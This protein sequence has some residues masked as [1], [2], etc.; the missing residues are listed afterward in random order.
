MMAQYRCIKEQHPGTLLFY[1]MG[2]FYEMFFD[3]A[4]EAADALSIALTKR[5]KSH[6][7]DIPMCGVPVHSA[8]GYLQTLIRKGHRVAVCEQTEDA[9][10]ARKRGAKSVVAREVV[11]LVT[12]GTLTEDGLLDAR[13][14]NFLAAI[15]R[16]R[17]QAAVA[18]TD[19]SSGSLQS[20]QCSAAQLPHHLARIDAAEILLSEAAED[21]LKAQLGQLA[22]PITEV[23]ARDFDSTD[24]ERRLKALFGVRSL[25]AFGAFERTELGALCAIILYLERTQK[26]RL[27]TL[28]PPRRERPEAIMQI[29]AATRRNLELVRDFSGRRE[30]SLL[31]TID[32]T[33]TAAGGRML[34]RRISQPSTV[35]AEIAAHHDEVAYCLAANR[36][37]EQVRALLRK[38]PD[39]ERPLSRLGLDRASP[40]DLGA[41]RTGLLLAQRICAV[42]RAG[43]ASSV[44]TA[45]LAAI[46]SMAE[47]ATDLDRCLADEVP[48]TVRDGSLIRVG[49]DAQL[50][51][52]RRSRDE[53]RSDIANLQRRYATLADITSLKIRHNN[54]L[55]YFV[56]TPASHAR[57]MMSDPLAEKFIHRQTMASAVRFTTLELTELESRIIGA[58]ATVI[59]I[60]NRHFES[61]RERVVAR[62]ADLLAAARA[63]A[64]LDVA[65]ALAETASLNAW[66]RPIIEEGVAFEIRGGRHPVVEGALR[67]AGGGD[68]IANDCHLSDASIRLVTGPNMSGKSTYLRQNAL[69]AILAQA[70]SFVPADSARI[71]LVT[72]LFS[73]VGAADDL[74][75]GQSTFMVEMVETATI[76]Q[77]ATP[78]AL[79]ILDEIGRGTATYDGLSIAWA[80]LEHLHEINRCRSLFATHYHELTQL[81]E[82]LERLTNATVAVSEWEGEVVFLHE[83]RDG[84]CD[85][86]YGVQ[87]A[88]LAGMPESAVAR[89]EQL[90][91]QF[92]SDS[93]PTFAALDDLPLFSAAASPPEDPLRDKLA[94]I[95]PDDLTPRAALELIYELKRSLD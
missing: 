24:G 85:R 48:L 2:D 61:L 60:E 33:L 80:T 21:A 74:A 11:R 70:G 92:E 50:D 19:I 22:V 65:T 44:F 12:P 49:F 94:G 82:R 68:F 30:T 71:G 66:R 34:E 73:R 51:E 43:E 29:D 46:E 1:R 87:V 83:V 76:L 26:G 20:V 14:H 69:I 86:S 16:R 38:Q 18:W 72:Q 23:A 5:G 55:G 31:G 41:I 36:L 8:D 91:R 63:L 54:V 6:G 78:T 57:S 95:T 75:R 25:A 84:C 32:C 53:Q 67:H 42:L 10:E 62:A 9:A 37:R 45:D 27:P 7:D 90:L 39:I 59:E 89:A 15:V 52:A 56:E 81:D 79:V 40:R 3:D 64:R 88:R 47:L 17:E 4:I 28:Q 58:G 35:P 13:T 93:T 77:Q